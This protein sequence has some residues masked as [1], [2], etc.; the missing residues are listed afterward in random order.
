MHELLDPFY[1][2]ASVPLELIFLASFLLI[3]LFALCLGIC[4]WERYGKRKSFLLIFP[5]LILL[6]VL[7]IIQCIPIRVNASKIRSYYY[8]S[9]VNIL[10]LGD[11]E[12]LSDPSNIEQVEI[13]ISYANSRTIETHWTGYEITDCFEK[14]FQVHFNIVKWTSWKSNDE[15]SHPD[16]LIMQVITQ[17]GFPRDHEGIDVFCVFSGQELNFY[18][19]VCYPYANMTLIPDEW[20]CHSVMRHELS[21]LF[22]CP[23]C[24]EDCVMNVNVLFGMPPQL[25]WCANC[26]KVIMSNRLRYG[27][28][29][30]SDPVPWRIFPHRTHPYLKGY[31]YE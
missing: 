28:I 4:L 30:Y 10:C 23:D 5:L 14:N 31:H 24:E 16:D 18:M 9:C 15:Y 12:F 6:V 29:A 25:N 2:L 27:R 1:D 8:D 13:A 3:G 19:A 26:K 11:E 22:L 7:L 21:H 17:K 20:L